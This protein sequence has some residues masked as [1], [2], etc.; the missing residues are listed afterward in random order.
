MASP[1]LDKKKDAQYHAVTATERWADFVE[2]T[3]GEAQDT[4]EQLVR[5][6]LRSEQQT[7]LT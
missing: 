2:A 1:P 5:N 6:Q 4:V 3:I 7:P